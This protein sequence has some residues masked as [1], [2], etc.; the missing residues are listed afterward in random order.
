[1]ASN[2]D[3]DQS[4][5]ASLQSGG[6]S[7]PAQRTLTSLST[8]TLAYLKRLF[9]SHATP[10][11]KWTPD[12]IRVFI[13]KVQGS[14]DV[15]SPEE[16]LAQLPG[17][18]TPDV[19]AAAAAE[20]DLDGFLAY[21]TSSH[22]S[23]V[24]P[25]RNEDFSW[26][27]A[28]YF[29]SSSHNTYLTGNQL[30]S[31]ST[32]GAYTNVL[33]RG[34]RCVEIDVWDGDESDA[35]SSSSSESETSDDEAAAKKAA[36]KE[37]KK[38]EKK[39]A[40]DKDKKTGWSEQLRS[41]MDKINISKKVDK[42][43]EKATEKVAEIQEA[44]TNK[45]DST[46]AAAVVEPR[47]LH[48][49][50]LTKDIRFRDV[51]LAIRESAFVASDM[52]LIVSLEVH[53][54]PQ[55]Q[56]VMVDIMKDVWA[57][58]LVTEPESAIE[59]LPSPDQ[60]RRKILIK[61]K[62]VPP[63]TPLDKV[64]T[65]SSEQQVPVPAGAPPPKPAKTI[66]ELARLAIY[67]QGV[68]FKGWTQPEAGM[69][70]H[71]FSISEKKFIDYHEKQWATLFNHNKHFLLRAY[72]AGFRIGSS[73]LNPAIFWGGGAQIVALNWQETD[74]GMML[75]EGM[76]TGTGGYVLKPEG[77]RSKLTSK[78]DISTPSPITIARKTVS[79]AFTF[80]SAQNLPLPPDEKSAKGFRPYVKVEL[81]VEASKN[82]HAESDGHVHDSEYKVRT[83]THKGCDLD[84]AGER[85]EFK[86]IPGLVEEL[87]FVRFTIRDDEFGRDD[88]AAW[89]C[90]KLDRLGQGYRFVHL[91]NTKG[92]ATD[93]AIL[94]KVEKLVV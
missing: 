76:F 60:L 48:G 34:C 6:G 27:L 90:V 9:E 78:E 46:T 49:Y 23:A 53:C 19:A 68:T 45:A 32:T 14:S 70:T 79:L 29:I 40:K 21:M 8:T 50:T 59:S 84:L 58:L 55:Q 24:L 81:H 15:V 72:P 74:E 33:L 36:L 35:E 42:I 44:M 51:C 12:Q 80:L 93:G 30:S 64:D 52:P 20:L 87:T 41:K 38:K 18:R 69:P 65:M 89:A 73:N 1:M 28:S 88:L 61:V 63:G 37:K 66:Q 92:E 39:E 83:K 54:S 75:N 3:Q 7:I 56:L 13:Q 67:T 94:V 57:G 10:E 17:N 86:A 25:V 2:Q 16:A 31:D 62:Y 77:Y 91:R 11:G 47:V 85:L 82:S 22:S 26:P 71:I 5:N 4:A 43:Q